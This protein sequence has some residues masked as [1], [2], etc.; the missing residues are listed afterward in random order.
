MM[1]NFEEATSGLFFD[2][3]RKLENKELINTWAYS[4]IVGSVIVVYSRRDYPDVRGNPNQSVINPNSLAGN[5]QL[6]AGFINP[7]S[8]Q[9]F[10]G[11]T[12][13]HTDN[14]H[15][16]SPHIQG[17]YIEKYYYSPFISQL[18]VK[19]SVDY[20]FENDNL[21]KFEEKLI[22]NYKGELEDN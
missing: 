19:E 13:F 6:T 2:I 3:K 5:F 12:I 4:N 11:S 17:E 18:S 22:E 9:G 15:L 7:E 10:M 16:G 21:K 14:V 20:S 8:I 1:S